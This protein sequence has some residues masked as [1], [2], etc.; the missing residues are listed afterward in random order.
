MP[1]IMLRDSWL[2][3]I[4][5][6]FHAPTKDKIDNLKD[7]FYEKLKRVFDKYLKYHMK[8]LLGD[9]NVKIGREYILKPTVGS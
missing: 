8:I 7:R 6:N 5:L 2:H 1:Y 9:F 4:V 3:F